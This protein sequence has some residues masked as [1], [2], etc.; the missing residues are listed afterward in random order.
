MGD[1]VLTVL[2]AVLV[3]ERAGSAGVRERAGVSDVVVGKCHLREHHDN[4]E[5]GGQQTAVTARLAAT[6]AKRHVRKGFYN[7]QSWRRGSTSSRRGLEEHARVG[8]RGS[9]RSEALNVNASRHGRGGGG[10]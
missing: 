10:G 9:T 8:G 3:E 4:E 5:E 6:V 7:R 2:T 1:K